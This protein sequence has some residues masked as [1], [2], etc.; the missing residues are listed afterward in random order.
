MYSNTWTHVFSNEVA[1]DVTEEHYHG[2]AYCKQIVADTLTVLKW[3]IQTYLGSS[4]RIA[5]ETFDICT[6]EGAK[7]HIEFGINTYG[8][9]AARLECTIT[10][11]E[12]EGYDQ[13]LEELKIALKNRLIQ[14]WK[15]CTWL[16]DMQS[17]YLCKEAY[18][19]AFIVENNLRAFASK[20]LIHFM[21]I[22]WLN[23]TGLEKE[24]ESVKNL[25]QK[26]IKRVPEFENI[27]ADFLSMTLETLE[28]VMFERKVYKD[29]IVLDKSQYAKV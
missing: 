9:K 3:G 13:K 26:F 4:E 18:E 29:T 8:R 27:N 2:D 1:C 16:V 25:K 10:A 7:Y 12:T 24:A 20:V 6:D 19:R 5:N 14:D 23:S 28:K 15:V 11:P 17:A 21:G 22:D